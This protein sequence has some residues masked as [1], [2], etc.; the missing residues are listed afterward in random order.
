[1]K[2]DYLPTLIFSYETWDMHIILGLICYSSSISTWLFPGVYF[3]LF[4]V[5]IKLFVSSG[6]V[7][8]L[9]FVYV[10]LV[11]SSGYISCCSLFLSNGLLARGLFL[12]FL[13]ASSGSVF[14]VLFYINLVVSS[15][16]VFCC[17]LYFSPSLLFQTP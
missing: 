12:L 6:S 14:V 11:V 7:F 2:K 13:V 15:G 5:F 1:M 8:L 17:S 16:S 4:F 3:M 9:I 10:N